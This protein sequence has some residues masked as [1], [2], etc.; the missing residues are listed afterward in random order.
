MAALAFHD[1]APLKNVIQSNQTTGLDIPDV[2][3]SP[4]VAVSCVSAPG[5]PP[6][7]LSGIPCTKAAPTAPLFRTTSQVIRDTCF[8]TSDDEL[9]D[10]RC[11]SMSPSRARTPSIKPAE[12]VAV[13]ARPRKIF[14]G[15]QI[16]DW[17]DEVAD[18]TPIRSFKVKQRGK[19]T[20]V[21]VS[22]EDEIEEIV[23]MAKIDTSS[24]S[25]RRSVLTMTDILSSAKSGAVSIRRTTQTKKPEKVPSKLPEE[26]PAQKPAQKIPS[27]TTILDSSEFRSN[28]EPG[29]TLV[30]RT[31][32]VSAAVP[33]T[34]LVKSSDIPFK[35]AATPRKQRDR[36]QG[37]FSSTWVHV[38]HSNQL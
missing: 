23:P 12:K 24:I 34:P 36:Q 11:L 9:S 30:G 7:D 21:F 4:A 5:T 17:D 32:L 8:G 26:P 3:I 37:G 22:D 25:R 38:T 35:S 14:K 31:S 16:D 6:V 18:S 15:K 27:P 28:L 33:N 19:K 29:S 10:V 20:L 1:D 13:S 2:A